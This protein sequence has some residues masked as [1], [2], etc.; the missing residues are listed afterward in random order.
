MVLV[1]MQE[2]GHQAHLRIADGRMWAI[3][4]GY[5]GGVIWGE[6]LEEGEVGLDV[7][8]PNVGDAAS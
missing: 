6:V 4:E 3:G 8:V 7:S 1:P 2:V 5:E